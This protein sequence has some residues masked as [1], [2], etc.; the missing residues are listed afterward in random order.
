MPGGFQPVLSPSAVH[1]AL[2]TGPADQQQ[3][4]IHQQTPAFGP[5][6]A[7]A[8]FRL[9]YQPPLCGPSLVAGPSL[10]SQTGWL[11]TSLVLQL[12]SRGLILTMNSFSFFFNFRERRREGER[13]RNINVCLP[14][15]HKRD[16]ARNP[17]MCPDWE[18]NQR[19][20]GLR[21]STQSTE[22]HHPGLNNEFFIL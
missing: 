1:S 8:S 20:F 15:M 4:Q 2:P 5:V 22:P 12:P 9:L 13:E 3:P 14:L 18:S 21:T 19:P 17:G 10:A 7:N 11:G 6:K 16:L